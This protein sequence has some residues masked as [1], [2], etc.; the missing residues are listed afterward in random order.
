[1]KN[2]EPN[3]SLENLTLRYKNMKIRI[4]GRSNKFKGE[5]FM[6]AFKVFCYMEKNGIVG[7]VCDNPKNFLGVF[8]KKS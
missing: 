8:E 3:S 2:I 4:D 6:Q 5:L 1:M 7:Y